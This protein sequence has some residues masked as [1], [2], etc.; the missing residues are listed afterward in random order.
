VG[1]GI[2]EGDQLTRLSSTTAVCEGRVVNS[3]FV[4]VSTDS[5]HVA[6]CAKPVS[7][8]REEGGQVERPEVDR[9][10]I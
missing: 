10:S 7:L 3:Q 1:S 6:E 8:R 5:R 2:E 9:V 4:D